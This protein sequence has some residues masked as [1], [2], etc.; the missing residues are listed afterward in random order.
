MEASHATG[1][2]VLATG[3]IRAAA[4][5]LYP[6]CAIPAI[7]GAD[8]YVSHHRAEKRCVDAYPGVG[9]V[10]PGRD[11]TGRTPNADPRAANVYEATPNHSTLPGDQWFSQRDYR[12]DLTL[13]RCG[14]LCQGQRE[15]IIL[16]RGVW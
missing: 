13:H 15:T 9:L 8:H 10:G 6:A 3:A 11:R 2:S 14:L 4:T 16:A 1:S 12:I 7:A 5:V